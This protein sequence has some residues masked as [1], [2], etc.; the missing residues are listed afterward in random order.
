M[1]YFWNPVKQNNTLKGA[2]KT[3]ALQHCK[4]DS[5]KN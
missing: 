3:E 2:E 1:M 4:Y 5:V